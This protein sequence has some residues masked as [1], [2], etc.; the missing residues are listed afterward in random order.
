M[1][2]R[3]DILM[4]SNVFEVIEKKKNTKSVFFKD[5]EVG[6]RLVFSVPLKRAGSS[7]GRSYAV[8]VTVTNV[9]TNKSD[10]YSFNQLPNLLDNFELI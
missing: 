4:Q 2:D 9:D 10:A 6:H 7:R 5:V 8:Y 3:Q 1:K